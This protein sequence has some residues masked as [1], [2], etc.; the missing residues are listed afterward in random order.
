M[1][2]Y[3]LIFSANSGRFSTSICSLL[4]EASP[5]SPGPGCLLFLLLTSGSP[6]PSD[7]HR[8]PCQYP[9]ELSH[10]SP[11]HLLA[12]SLKCTLFP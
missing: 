10:L 4:Q 2:F 8:D 12:L 11:W 6:P 5:D 1:L 3:P 7:P 9:V